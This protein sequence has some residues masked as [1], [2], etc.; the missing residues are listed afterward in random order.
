M[1]ATTDAVSSEDALS[2]TTTSTSAWQPTICPRSD[3]NCRLSISARLYVGIA[4]ER[5]G[6]GSCW[7]AIWPFRS[8]MTLVLRSASGWPRSEQGSRRI[9]NLV[10]SQPTCSAQVGLVAGPQYDVRV[11]AQ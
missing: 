6:G 9:G 8:M 1:P 11:Y 4:M 7:C 2:E 3:P 10:C 5:T